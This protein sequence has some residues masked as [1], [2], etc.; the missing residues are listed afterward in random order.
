[1]MSFENVSVSSNTELKLWNSL[2]P[3]EL[4]DERDSIQREVYNSFGIDADLIKQK[5][6]D[7]NCIIIKKLLGRR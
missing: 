2:V 5:L 1:M 7:I 6:T 3:S 4:Y